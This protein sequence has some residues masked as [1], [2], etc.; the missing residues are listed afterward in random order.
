[1]LQRVQL[2]LDRTTRLGLV[3]LAREEG[4]SASDLARELLSE[5]INE[6]KRIK[7]KIKKI[8]AAESLLL[9]AKAAKK[10]TRYDHG[11]RDLSINYDKY[12]Y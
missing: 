12:I 6:R 2:V 3:E 7:K 8:S 11:P 9:M 5:K 1:M 4:R 10:L